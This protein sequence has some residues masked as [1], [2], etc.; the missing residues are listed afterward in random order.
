VDLAVAHAHAAELQRLGNDVA[1]DRVAPEP[2]KLDALTF[3]GV[4]VVSVRLA[5]VRESL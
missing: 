2:P 3:A 1:V 5:P 4:S